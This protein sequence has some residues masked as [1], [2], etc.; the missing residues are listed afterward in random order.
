MSCHRRR[1]NDG[2]SLADVAML[3]RIV[4]KSTTSCVAVVGVAVLSLLLARHTTRS[5]NWCYEEGGLDPPTVYAAA[6]AAMACLRPGL[7]G[8]PSVYK[9]DALPRSHTGATPPTITIQTTQSFKHTHQT[10]RLTHHI[11]N[12]TQA[13]RRSHL[14][15]CHLH[16]G[17]NGRREHRC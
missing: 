16:S 7:N 14:L 4:C 17:D 13:S 6:C 2:A 11:H 3:R 12:A 9:T 10:N 8:G 15:M 5:S 1:V